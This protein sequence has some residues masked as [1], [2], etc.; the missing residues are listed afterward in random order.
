[1]TK[2]AI[3]GHRPEDLEN[4][5]WITESLEK[6][7]IGLKPEI[8]YQ[9]MA[10]GADLMSAEVAHKVGIPFIAARP[11]STHT[12]R[13]EDK[14]L[15]EW[16]MLNALKVVNV[17]EIDYYSGPHLYHNRNE[18]MVDNADIVI[19]IWNGKAT[20]GTAA[21]VRYAKKKAKTIIQINPSKKE[22]K[23]IVEATLF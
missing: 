10:A 15:Y 3:T 7:L 23:E 21:C 1:M 17:D 20:G 19:A 5:A 4:I 12:P 22:I 9:G 8:L 14:K 6:L 13:I 16:T 11:W 18:Y 2:V